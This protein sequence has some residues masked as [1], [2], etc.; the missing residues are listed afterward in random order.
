MSARHLSDLLIF[1][2]VVKEGSLAAAGREL[3]FS[4]A[5]VSK[6]LQ[7]LEEGIGVR[8]I[9][10][11]TRKLSL[12]DEGKLYCEYCIRILAELDEA[13]TL[14]AG[15]SREPSGTLRVTVP[16]AFGRQHIAPLVPEFLSRYPKV[17]LSLHLSDQR[18]DLIEEGYDLA[19]R[20]GELRDSNLI[21][22]QLGVDR[23]VLV[24]SPAYIAQHGEPNH[25]ED[26]RSHNALLFANPGPLDFWNFID[27]QGKEHWVKVSGN[28]ETNNCDAL[29]AIILAGLG[30]AL[31]PLWDVWQDI[32]M[33]RMVALLPD[34]THPSFPIQALYPNRRYLSQKVRAFIDMLCERFGNIPY[35]ESDVAPNAHECS[36][37]GVTSS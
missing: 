18:V 17:R 27:A 33:G 31:R 12:T 14:I 16:A 21:V 37:L 29:R 1:T 34:H 10:R 15:G 32:R 28:F 26:L 25:P 24:A 11:S 30:V 22:R 19:V 4:S 8:L 36:G 13:E 20:I 3:G 35:W 7:R 2:R 5:V 6:R 9:N 23:R